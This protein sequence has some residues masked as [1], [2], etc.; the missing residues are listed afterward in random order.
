LKARTPAGR[1]LMDEIEGFKMFL[2]AAEKDRIRQL[3]GTGV[4][5]GTFDKYLPY[6]LALDVEEAWAQQLAAA[7]APSGG[8]ALARYTPRWYS[9]ADL[10][11]ADIGRTFGSA[12]SVALSSSSTDTSGSSGGSYGGG[13]SSGGGGGGGGGGGW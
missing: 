5:P 4:T 6:A 2:G 12:L 1:K 10:D 11:L 7:L 8:I 3:D 13:G 9:G